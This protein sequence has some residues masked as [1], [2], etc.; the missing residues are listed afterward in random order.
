MV[1]TDYPIIALIVTLNVIIATVLFAYVYTK[2]KDLKFWLYSFIILTPGV[3]LSYIKLFVSFPGIDEIS[4]IF[5]VGAIFSLTYAV[6]NEYRE[7]FIKNQPNTG[8]KSSINPKNVM[9]AISPILLGMYSLLLGLMILNVTLLLKIYLRKKTPTHAFLVLSLI[10]TFLE[11]LGMMLRAM[12]IE[13]SYE[14][15]RGMGVYYSTLMVVT[16]LVALIELKLKKSYKALKE[17]VD[18]AS[19]ASVNTANMATELA[20]SASEVNASAEEISSTTQNLA[21]KSQMVMDSTS[22]VQNVLNLITNIA[23]QTNLLALNASIE[24]GRAGQHGKGFA[25]VAEEVRK[26]SEEAKNAVGNSSNKIKQILEIINETYLEMENIN[27]STE[28]QTASMEEI[29][30]TANRLGKLAEEL[31]NSLAVE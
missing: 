6:V 29:T 27:A 8:K 17:V 24:A 7:T 26:L 2:R 20:A 23:K 18:S 14:F 28:E 10:A 4:S 25:V 3:V 22:D 12:E 11:V 30:A 13:G 9:F 21:S 16:G 15:L 31:R 19:E 1:E 5:Y